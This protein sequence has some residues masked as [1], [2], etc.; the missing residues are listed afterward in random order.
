MKKALLLIIIFSL[1]AASVFAQDYLFSQ[2]FNSPNTL[3]SAY[4][5]NYKEDY[6][7]RF[8][9]RRQWYTAHVPFNTTAFNADLNIIKTP[10]YL[11]KMG[12]G[13][14]FLN[15][16]LGSDFFK[17][18][19]LLASVAFI[20]KLDKKQHHTL[21]IGLQGGI[22]R[23]SIQ[24]ENLYFENQFTVFGEFDQSVNSR[25]QLP[26]GWESMT[27]Q[28]NAGFVYHVH[29]KEGME[30]EM[31]L[32]LRNVLGP[33]D[34]V[35]DLSEQVLT[36]RPY[37]YLGNFKT[38]HRLSDRIKFSPMLLYSYQR[39]AMEINAG[40]LMSYRLGNE[41]EGHKKALRLGVFHR[42]MDSFIA[43]AGMRWGPIQT[44]LSYD[45]GVSQMNQVA[46]SVDRPFAGSFEVSL[47][48]RGVFNRLLPDRQSV[49]C[50]FF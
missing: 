14:T 8:L 10:I 50:H 18:Q 29:V 28:L 7:A 17:N 16:D 24:T 27:P 23:K 47:T 26:S 21:S 3:N 33:S 32:S 19:Q 36:K 1:C 12:F 45:F 40:G 11:D 41:L 38:T 15:E 30:L 20:K 2:Y 39:M 4:T 43:L 44:D 13:L 22:Q 37:R 49:P 9:H 35:L 25:E 34:D 42:W 5:G 46:Q 31:G 6:S 48:Y